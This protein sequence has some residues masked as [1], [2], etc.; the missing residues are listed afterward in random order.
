MKKEIHKSKQTKTYTVHIYSHVTRAMAF[1]SAWG[2]VSTFR[3]IK[4]FADKPM[5]QVSAR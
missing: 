2:P 3:D 1:S 4:N 5:V